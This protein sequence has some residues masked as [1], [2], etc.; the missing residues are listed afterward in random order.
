MTP[1]EKARELV[2]KM[3]DTQGPN[4]GIT[5]YEAIDC[6]IIAVD[7]II[8]AYPDS[9]EIVKDK[10]KDNVDITII[11]TFK[12]NIEYWQEVKTEIEKL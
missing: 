2:D 6:A 10:T 1:K 7:E 8:N 9:Y 11:A 12:S 3:Y 5:Y 4:Y